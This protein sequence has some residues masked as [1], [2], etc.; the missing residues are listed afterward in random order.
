MHLSDET[1]F[2]VWVEFLQFLQGPTSYRTLQ[3]YGSSKILIL[4]DVFD[5]MRQPLS[6]RIARG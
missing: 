1:R 5:V 2:I 3:N 4:Y 6:R